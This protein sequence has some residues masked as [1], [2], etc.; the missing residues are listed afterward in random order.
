MTIVDSA[1]SILMLY[2]YAGFPE[3]SFRLFERSS[4]QIS[5]AK[6]LSQEGVPEDMLPNLPPLTDIGTEQTKSQA[7]EEIDNTHMPGQD[8]DVIQSQ[9][10][11]ILGGSIQSPD[12]AKQ[13]TAELEDFKRKFTVKQNTMSNLSVVL[14][15]V[16][17]LLAF[18]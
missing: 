15:L 9:I 17:I 13:D 5:K 18:R 4:T 12:C 8:M 6:D 14:T 7:I 3:K 16:S 11:D 10:T 2:S 1:D